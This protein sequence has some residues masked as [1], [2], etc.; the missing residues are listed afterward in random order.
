MAVVFTGL[1]FL[2]GVFHSRNQ[3][4]H[5]SVGLQ[6]VGQRCDKLKLP[7]HSKVFV[8]R[9]VVLPSVVTYHFRLYAVLE[10]DFHG[11]H[12]DSL[13][14]ARLWHHLDD[15][16][17]AVI[18]SHDEVRYKC[19]FIHAYHAEFLHIYIYAEVQHVSSVIYPPK[20]R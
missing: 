19:T 9:R 10:E 6:V 7:R 8:V 15:G 4:L 18:V 13:A 3:E 17:L 11:C 12:N 16:E 5:K 20:H 2:E 1:S 14:R